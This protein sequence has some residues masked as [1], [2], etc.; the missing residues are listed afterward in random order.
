VDYTNI[1]FE[2]LREAMLA[3]ARV[4]LPE[5]TDHSENDLGVM[6][7]DLFA[8]A[9]DL[10]LYYQN[11][12]AQNLFPATSDEPAALIQL[13]R[14]IGY[15]L[16][17]AAP[18][19][20]DLRLTIDSTVTTPPVP[21]PA[22]SQFFAVTPG[23]D[24]LTFET[25]RAVTL[26]NTQWT[27]ADADGRRF[28]YISVVQG[29]TVPDE[30]IGVSDGS[31]SQ[32]FTLRQTPV[33]DGS[34][35]VNVAEPGGII[36]RWSVVPTLADSG[37]A[38]RHVTVQRDAA[39]MATVLFGDGVNGMAP[40]SG[41]TT[42]PV[43]ITATYRVGGGPAG[44]V[45][46]KTEF[47]SALPFI[48]A[49]TNP[50]AAA[51]GEN[52]EGVQRARDFAPRLFR[53]QERAVTE[54]DYTDLALQVPGVGKARAV[55]ISWRQIALYVAPTGQVAPPSELLVRDI[56][57]FFE[58]R[59]MASTALKVIGPTPVDI[60]IRARVTAQPYVLKTDVVAAV[61]RAVSEYLAFEA[62]DF[63]QQVF[64]SRIYDVIQ[65][66][67]EVLSV[68]ITQFSTRPNP[69]PED[70]IAADG[71]IQLGANE[72]P[73]L[74]YRDNPE[75]LL[76]PADPSFRPPLAIEIRGGVAS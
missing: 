27:P 37:P 11:R 70:A 69:A 49:A 12:I 52:G 39:G 32:R 61:E 60:Y 19:T 45:Q 8:F 53:T 3:R 9:S 51:G 18:A 66:L 54:E 44:N 55:A 63:G 14:L 22:G 42:L 56:L 31:P 48:V 21:I 30:A 26:Q 10:T 35:V 28:A 47:R 24:T 29:T 57:Q 76:L 68:L 23:G 71:L 72:L 41:T 17:P 50:A 46:A 25:V 65:S 34:I 4:T 62:I 16:R 15:E 1:G 43:T 74:G 7:I 5:W 38:D 13:L 59:R 33:I 40:P 36:T 20:V 67:P 58:S 2:A 64:L 75:T 73:R 6:L